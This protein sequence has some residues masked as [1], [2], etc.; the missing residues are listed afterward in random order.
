[1]VNQGKKIIQVYN[2][3]TYQ[4][5]S[6]DPVGMLERLY[7]KLGHEKFIN[8]IMIFSDNFSRYSSVPI[9]PLA[10]VHAALNDLKIMQY[11]ESKLNWFDEYFVI[12]HP[13]GISKPFKLEADFIMKAL[14][15]NFN[16][17]KLENEIP[18]FSVYKVF[19]LHYRFDELS[20]SKVR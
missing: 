19:P 12:R 13:D 1:M 14:L 8:N 16:L 15:E 6:T 10:E 5:N 2:Y 18:P 4:E 7:L 9:T 3:H 11:N 20:F 17:L